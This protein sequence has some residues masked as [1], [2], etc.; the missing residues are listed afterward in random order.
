MHTD[1]QYEGGIDALPPMAKLV[2]V[3]AFL[4]SKTAAKNDRPVHIRVRPRCACEAVQTRDWYA[5]LAQAGRDQ[6]MTS[7]L[8]DPAA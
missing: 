8:T 5:T 7:V 3:A 1:A 4:A 2:L 6:H